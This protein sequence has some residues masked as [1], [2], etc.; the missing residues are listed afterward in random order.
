MGDEWPTADSVQLRPDGNGPRDGAS[1]GPDT[2][3]RPPPGAGRGR[4]RLSSAEPGA[5]LEKMDALR[6][7]RLGI[8]DEDFLAVAEQLV[9]EL[10]KRDCAISQI[11]L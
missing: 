3:E 11:S 9:N 8:S 10:I 4:S 2:A 6:L 1:P 7:V 5:E